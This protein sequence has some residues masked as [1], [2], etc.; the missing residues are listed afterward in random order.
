VVNSLVGLKAGDEELRNLLSK[1]ITDLQRG[2]R[3]AVQSAVDFKEIA[4]PASV[5]VLSRGIVN[6]LLGMASGSKAKPDRKAS[7]EAAAFLLGQLAEA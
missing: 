4:A 2:L 1:T 6:G 5:E 3:R 7:E